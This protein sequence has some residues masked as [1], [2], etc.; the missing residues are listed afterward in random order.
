MSG[1]DSNLVFYL[2]DA[3]GDELMVLERLEAALWTVREARCIKHGK[4]GLKDKLPHKAILIW[5]RE[6]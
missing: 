3:M 2:L 6:C 1:L 4:I 5:S